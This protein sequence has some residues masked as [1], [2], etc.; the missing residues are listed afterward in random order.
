M[1]AKLVSE[2]KFDA[3]SRED[4]GGK[5]KSPRTRRQPQR[6]GYCGLDEINK[7]IGSEKVLSPEQDGLQRSSTPES[8]TITFRG[9]N[10]DDTR[11]PW[12]TPVTAL[13]AE[14]TPAP[15]PLAELIAPTRR[16]PPQPA[17]RQDGTYQ[18]HE[19]AQRTFSDSNGKSPTPASSTGKLAAAGVGGT[20]STTT[21]NKPSVNFSY[22][23]VLTRKPKTITERWSPRG[24][25]QDKTLA[26]LLKELP[27][28]DDL[29]PSGDDSQGLIFTIESECMRTVERLAG[30]DEEG[31][32][33]MKRYINMEIREWFARRMRAGSVGKGRLDVDVL[34]DRI[35]SDE[36]D[37]EAK[38]RVGGLF[39]DLELDW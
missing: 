31:F 15:E 1:Q 16:E 32:A 29:L 3:T 25:F 39:E 34:I 33:S 22:R 5:W 9:S 13:G 38:S 4:P 8:A 17:T 21:A 37:D 35:A 18:P 23:V 27:F 14:T 11:P 10:T 2:D 7:R 28:G 19:P 24:R 30:D 36:D 12:P 6:E 20:S 26:E